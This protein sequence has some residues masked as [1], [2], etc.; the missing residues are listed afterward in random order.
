MDVGL[1]VKTELD[2][3]GCDRIERSDISCRIESRSDQYISLSQLLIVVVIGLQRIANYL[4][5]DP[6]CD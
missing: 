2:Y 5:T 4:Y 3:I 1:G 6:Q